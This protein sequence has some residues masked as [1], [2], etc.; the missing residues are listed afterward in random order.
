[1]PYIWEMNRETY[2]GLEII[3]EPKEAKNKL[4]I[5]MERGVIFVTHFG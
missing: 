2:D 4:L 1:M 3:L 5:H